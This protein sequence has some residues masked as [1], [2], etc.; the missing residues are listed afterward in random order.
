MR[1]AGWGRRAVLFVWVLFA[2]FPV[3]WTL[4]TAFKQQVDIYDGPRFIP[5]VDF[6]PTLQ[7][8]RTLF[9]DG[10]G[11]FLGKFANSVVFSG[12]SSLL[13]V[14]LGGFAAYGL[15]RYR[16]KYGPYRND[17]LSFLIVSQR[18]MPPIVSVLAL[19]VVFVNLRLLDTAFGMILAY[20]AMNLPLTVYLLRTFFEAIP[21]EVEHAAALDGYP[22]W[23]RLL[24]VVF[25][26]A[27]PG[28]AAAFL[29]SFFFAWNDFLFSLML[30]FNDAQTL[31][32]YIT[33][34]NAQSQPLWWLISAV[35]LV[36]LVPPAIVTVVLDRFMARQVLIGGMR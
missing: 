11:D 18:I 23:Q 17:D 20:T 12:V 10:G 15:A 36:A 6:E 24:R 7:A 31:P 3:Y 35:G 16:Y 14:I 25:P 34:L 30:T 19:Y 5:F 28:L 22:Q 9:G 2:L 27:A 13:A 21:V 32:L 26:L 4:I 29:L 8:W 1:T 33:S